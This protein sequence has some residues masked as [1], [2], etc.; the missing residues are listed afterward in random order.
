MSIRT[1][2]KK[3]FEK[4]YWQR[5]ISHTFTDISHLHCIGTSQIYDVYSIKSIQILSSEENINYHA[6][7]YL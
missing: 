3:N 7:S 4:Y 2:Q 1:S 5:F 6:L